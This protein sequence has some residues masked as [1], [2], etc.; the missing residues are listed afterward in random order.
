MSQPDYRAPR[1]RRRAAP[2]GPGRPGADIPRP[3][4][5]EQEPD[6]G[7]VR[8]PGDITSV[9]IRAGELSACCLAS[10]LVSL[11]LMGVLVGVLAIGY[12][13]FK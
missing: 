6:E 13:L 1:T 10:V 7:E 4:R 11:V 8:S 3:R 12:T 2:A 9:V 5:R